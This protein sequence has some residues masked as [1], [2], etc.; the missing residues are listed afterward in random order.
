[1]L[2]ISG[3]AQRHPL[4]GYYEARPIDGLWASALAI[5]TFAIICMCCC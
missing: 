5:L 4:Y 1:M 3:G 2:S